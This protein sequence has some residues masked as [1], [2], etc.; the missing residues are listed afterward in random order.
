MFVD[1]TGDVTPSTTN[2]AITRFA[3]LTGVIFDRDY[4]GNTFEPGWR[5]VVARTF[6]TDDNGNPPVL[7]RRKMVSPPQMGPFACL[8]DKAKRDAWNSSCLDMMTRAS[9]TVITVS[10]DKVGFYYHH[11]K[12]T[13]DVYETLFQNAVERFFYFLKGKGT[14]DVVVEAQNAGADQAIKS[15][16]RKIMDE[17]TEHIGSAKLA[18]VFESKEIKIVPKTK[19]LIGLQMADLLARPSFAH[20]RA[21][22]T[23]DTSDLA[24]F[25]REIAPILESYKFY[26]SE[27]GNPDGYG[28]VWR[29]QKR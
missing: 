19:G 21:V 22:Y 3:S 12:A 10:L 27:A 7:H 14:G 4:L 13:L 18:K 29:P 9:Y 5:K 25:A 8:H 20:C 15:R 17:G 11:P 16:Y 26:R 6:G 28:R 1:D 24:G 2:N 23:K